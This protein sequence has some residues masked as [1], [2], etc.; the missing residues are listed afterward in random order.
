[1]TQTLEKAIFAGGCFWCMVE[2]FEE[3]EGILSVRSGYTAGHTENPTYEQVCSKQTGHTEAVEIIFDSSQVT[4]KELLD[5]YWQMTDP[6]DAMGQFEDRGDN[7]R[8]V[9]FYLN[10]SQ[11]ELAEQS[12]K[13][14]AQAAIFDAPIVT[15]IEEAQPFYPA[16]EYHQAFYRKNPERYAQSSKIRHDFLERTWQNKEK[17]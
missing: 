14:L 9:I 15:T 3:R 11:K 13:E 10:Q 17:R 7:Y 6:T 12:K 8:P 16:E 5:L 4:Y 2:P 1:M